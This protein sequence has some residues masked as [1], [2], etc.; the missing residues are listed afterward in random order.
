[1][2][3]PNLDEWNQKIHIGMMEVMDQIDTMLDQTIELI[4]PNKF[5]DSAVLQITHTN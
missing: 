5:V 2:T 3:S 4:A 1:M